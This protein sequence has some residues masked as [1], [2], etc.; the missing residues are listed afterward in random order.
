MLN[1][2]RAERYLR[3]THSEFHHRQ[4]NP[5]STCSPQACERLQPE[6]PVP[7]LRWR[8][9][10]ARKDHPMSSIATSLPTAPNFKNLR[11]GK[12]TIEALEIMAWQGVP[13]H[14]AAELVEM[15]RDN[16]ERAFGLPKV[17]I[18]WNQ[19]TQYIRQNEGQAAV[20]RIGE[21]ARSASSEHVRLEANKWLAGVEGVAP[22]SRVQG[23][24]RHRHS[25]EGFDY[26]EEEDIHEVVEGTV[27]TDE[28]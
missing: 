11:L 25:F 23:I 5:G 18:R 19:V 16:L 17:R 8:Q 6:T 2:K 22:I 14:K 15:R 3:R 1:E 24:Y 21:L 20:A 12:K 27:Y 10:K 9:S 4:Q 26:G 13:L 28:D 7:H